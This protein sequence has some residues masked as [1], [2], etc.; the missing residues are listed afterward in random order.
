MCQP[1]SLL[2]PQHVLPNVQANQT[3]SGGSG[4]FVFGGP[5]GKAGVEGENAEW[6]FNPNVILSAK[7]AARA[8]QQGSKLTA[9]GKPKSRAGQGSRGSSLL[10]LAAFNSAVASQSKLYTSFE[11]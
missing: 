4:P 7:T 2:G 10:R 1:L 11:L 5:H 3:A 9:E 8:S 6:Q